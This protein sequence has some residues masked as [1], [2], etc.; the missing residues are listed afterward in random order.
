[1]K[2]SNFK[3]LYIVLCKLTILIAQ[4]FESVER[5]KFKIITD[6]IIDEVEKGIYHSLLFCLIKYILDLLEFINSDLN[7]IEEYV[8]KSNWIY[9]W[10]K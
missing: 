2:V 3:I 5:E 7:K 10:K 4:F 9:T 1:M 6:E 8:D